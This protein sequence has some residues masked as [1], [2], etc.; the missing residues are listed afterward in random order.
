M[1]Y[2]AASHR[3]FDDVPNNPPLW[4]AAI[5]LVQAVLP[6]PLFFLLPLL[7]VIVAVAVAWRV[8]RRHGIETTALFV[9]TGWQAPMLFEAATC[10]RSYAFLI[11]FLTLAFDAWERDRPW[12][13]AAF[14]LAASLTHHL[15][16]LVGA[17]LVL[18]SLRMKPRLPLWT[19]LAFVPGSA[20]AAAGFSGKHS[21]LGTW[22]WSFS[23]VGYHLV[24][25]AVVLA[26]SLGLARVR[27]EL[28]RVLA[29]CVVVCVVVAALSCVIPMRGPYLW[30]SS[31]PVML[32]AAGVVDVGL[33]R[34]RWT[35]MPAS[36][37]LLLCLS[38]PVV[39]GAK[40]VLDHRGLQDLAGEL[41]SRALRGEYVVLYPANELAVVHYAFA[42]YS[43]PSSS[44]PFDGAESV[45]P[46]V[47]YERG[48][49]GGAAYSARNGARLAT[50]PLRKP[51]SIDPDADCLLLREDAG[52]LVEVPADFRFERRFGQFDEY[53][54]RTDS[55]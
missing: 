21:Q 47:L 24:V 33:A 17:G 18:A 7:A 32:L 49:T 8:G 37:L 46:F 4:N 30:I 14:G 44:R 3:V 13:F 29:W 6:A 11:A 15:G 39:L 23:Q 42:G 45:G 19:L 54:R 48:A 31:V 2:S 5:V 51:A 38:W 55:K 16:S 34:W 26:L 20:I 43:A 25:G 41:R 50:L 28:G 22:G 27:N 36:I 1:V 10:Y 40:S 35:V 53:A 52:G 12:A 9:A